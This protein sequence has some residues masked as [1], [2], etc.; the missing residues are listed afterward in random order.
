MPD[1]QPPTTTPIGDYAVVGDMQTCALVSRAGSVDWLC[2]PRFDSPSCFTALLGTPE[3]GRWLLGPLGKARS[4]RRYVGDTFVLETT[5]ETDTG[6][7]RVVDV[8]P[9]S[10]D[11]ADIIRVVEGVSGTVRMRHEWVVRFSYGKITPWVSRHHGP[12][13]HDDHVITAVAGPD[14]LV[15]RGTRLPH[16]EDGRHVDE[17]DVSAG[18]RLSFATTWCPSYLPVPGE[19][20]REGTI[21]ATR[22][23]WQDW[24]DRFDGHGAYRD[25]VIR[26]LLVLRLLTHATT[27]GIVAAATTSLPEDVGGE[28]N[29]DYRYCWLR[30][31]S[32]TLEALMGAGFVEE[33]K[34]WRRWLIRAVA[35]DPADMQIMYAVD[36]ARELPERELDFLPG[37][38]GS[39][40]VRVGNGAVAQ[41][42]T[43]VLG[44][45]MMALS[46]GRDGGLTESDRSWKIQ[47]ALVDTLAEHWEEPDNGLW[48]IRGPLRHFTHSRVMVWAAFDRAVQGVERH[49]LP[50][51]VEKWRTL[52]DTVKR[53][54]LA[55]GFDAERNTFTQHYD[56]HEVDASLLLIPVC[57]FL[58]ADDPRVLGT[59]DAI[60]QDLMHDGLLLRYRTTTGVDGLPG[61]EHPFLACSFWLVQALAMAGRHDR[62]REL[63][64]RLVGLTNDVGL[65]SEEYDPTGQRMVGNFPQAFSHLTLIGAAQA[66][67]GVT[68]VKA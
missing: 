3:H 19:L 39:R 68:T 28:R 8:M 38:A 30:D 37:Y 54:V 48:E 26:S 50:G 18:D 20:D 31:A 5:H 11:R 17:F 57:G 56:T 9:T 42:Q 35:G 2:L 34:L 53:E 63:M 22:E 62:A 15:L 27:G 21:E 29:W 7:V 6:V 60:E 10:D 66:L 64:D 16:A 49:G 36:G 51:P 1:A 13:G 67:S 12:G 47:R 45:V 4:T 59:I 43:D 40:P 55:K 33:T 41:R 25:A 58:P 61:T 24:A 65:L 32:L 52:R 14:M 46:D 23:E 44:E